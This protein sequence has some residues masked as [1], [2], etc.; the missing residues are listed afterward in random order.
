[1]E[2]VMS[3]MGDSDFAAPFVPPGTQRAAKTAFT[4][5]P[6]SLSLIVSMGFTPAQAE[7]ALRET[8]NDV[9]RAAD[10]IFSHQGELEAEPAPAADHYRDGRGLYRLQA[11][12]SHMGGSTQVGHYVCHVRKDGRWCIFNDEKVAESQEPPRELAYLY[13]YRRVEE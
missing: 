12:V 3:H 2:W 9:Q 5:D 7:R 1:M 4:A 8:G 11:F 6:E 10:W 13:M